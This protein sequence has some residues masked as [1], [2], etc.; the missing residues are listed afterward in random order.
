M[1]VLLAAVLAA[2]AWGIDL[3]ALSSG[4]TMQARIFCG[5]IGALLVLLLAARAATRLAQM[6]GI[7]FGCR[8]GAGIQAMRMRAFRTGRR[9]AGVALLL[10][11]TMFG[12]EAAALTRADV[13]A[14]I[15]AA[16]PGHPINLSGR[17]LA[18]ADLSGL[19][20]R[21][22]NLAH[23]DLYNVKLDDANLT[24]AD[25]AGDRLDLAWLMRTNLT[26][27]D[28]SHVLL[29]GPITAPGMEDMPKLAP[30]LAGADFSGARII[31][32]LNGDA[33]GADFSHAD[34]GARLRNQ[35]MGLLHTDMN[36]ANLRRANFEDANLAYASLRFADL[37]GANFQGASLHWA[38][39]SGADLTGANLTGA[40]FTHADLTD[41]ILE[42]ARGLKTVKALETVT[43]LDT[44]QGSKP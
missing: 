39:L 38:D 27:A 7:C 19:D 36:G 42:H 21:G 43:G 11:A 13:V 26:R 31:A 40:D 12:A 29:H 17:S 25:L 4:E 20:L 37:T 23:A 15:R 24:G 41:A 22:A 28:L 3:Q 35:S 34:L 10:I 5:V 16:G 8:S 1:I 44:V 32:R 6:L 18:G 30:I 2:S 9:G 33:E 14:A